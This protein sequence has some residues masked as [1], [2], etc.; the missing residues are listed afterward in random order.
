MVVMMMTSYF[1]KDSSS[2]IK[3]GYT[4]NSHRSSAFT[5]TNQRLNYFN[6]YYYYYYYYY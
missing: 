3:S 1:R 4:I 5:D 2:S 6:C